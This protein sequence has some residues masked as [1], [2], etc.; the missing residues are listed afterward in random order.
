MKRILVVPALLLLLSG[1]TATADGSPADKPQ[2]SPAASATPTPTPTVAAPPTSATLAAELQAAIPTI[3]SASAITEEN[4]SNDMIGRPNGYVGGEFIADSR[5]T[6]CY[7]G[8][9]ACGA[10]IEDWV[11]AADAQTRS[12]YIQGILKGSPALGSE[13]NYIRDGLLLRVSG[14]L[15][16]SAAAEYEAVFVAE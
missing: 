1:C 11:T 8:G 16:P 4:D 10:V 3:T 9:V 15:P 13:Y 6:E 14:E 2:S 7:D 5:A 12:D